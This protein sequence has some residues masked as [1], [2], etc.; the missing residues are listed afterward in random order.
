MHEGH[1]RRL[2]QKLN[3]GDNLFEHELLEILLFNAYPRKNVNP[4]AHALL[5]RFP[6]IAEVLAADLEELKSVEGV[7]ENVA[8]YL[9]CIGRV[10]E[11]K[12]DCDSFAIVGNTAQLIAFAKA[13]LGGRT[14]EHAELYFV[15]KACGVKRIAAFTCGDPRRVE[16]KPEE[17]VK[18]ISV[19]RPYGVYLAHN[20]TDCP[21][22]PS[23]A[24][25]D[26]TKKV[27]LICSLNNVRLLDHVIVAP[28]GVYSYFMTNRLDEIAE[29][30]SAANIFRNG[31]ND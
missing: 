25:D 16:L 24:D 11:R 31:G 15:D 18:L 4:V 5:E 26:L 30:F 22:E 23:A 1:R 10:L 17:V 6:S 19:C 9:K 13:R 21:A 14:S 28:D 29:Q 27:Q 8:L 2:W 20:H 7:G 12:N 3:S